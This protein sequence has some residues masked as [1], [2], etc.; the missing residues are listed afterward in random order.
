MTRHHTFY[1]VVLLSG[2]SLFASASDRWETLRAINMVEN[3][4][5]QTGYGSKGELGPYQFR[6][7]TWRM[8][9][10]KPFR[11]ANDRTTADQVAVQH[12]EWI[13]ERFGEAGIDANSYNIALAWNCGISAVIAGRIPM[14]TY[15][16]ADQ[17][18]NLVEN[19]RET[20]L[21][22]EAPIPVVVTFVTSKPNA[23]VAGLEFQL[24]SQNTIP[25]FKIA[26]EPFQFRI[27]GESPRFVI[28]PT[29]SR[30]VLVYN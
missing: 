23:L 27:A 15:Q 5:N 24:A 25:A 18:N 4:T 21:V 12:Y 30:F 29:P 20:A 28:T 14:Q 19:F 1:L 16:Y 3:P 22:A 8:H 17:V 2:F 6:S 26:A 7:G 13:K 10:N 11:L 9:T